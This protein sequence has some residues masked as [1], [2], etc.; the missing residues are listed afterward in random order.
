MSKLVISVL[1][2]IVNVVENDILFISYYVNGQMVYPP[3]FEPVIV[4]LLKSTVV[5]TGVHC[6]LYGPIS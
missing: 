4:G 5:E 6:P 1:P 3:P 2:V